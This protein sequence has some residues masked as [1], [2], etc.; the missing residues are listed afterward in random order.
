MIINK[1]SLEY[2]PNDPIT[3][4]KI[5][6][7]YG[8]L[9]WIKILSFT[10]KLDDIF[11]YQPWFVNHIN[12]WYKLEVSCWKYHNKFI[13]VK[14]KNINDRNIANKLI[15]IEIIINSKQLPPLDHGNYYLKDLLQCQVIHIKGYNMGTIVDFIKTGPNYVIVVKPK[16]KNKFNIGEILIP[17][18]EKKIIKM[19]N[20]HKK[21]IEVDWNPI[22]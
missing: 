1:K 14:L 2:Y 22:F 4:G 20:I 21:L 17:F 10:E 13:I 15:N 5:I 11:L 12:K 9:G 19:V 8:I 6:G 18:I 3:L 7:V 16:I